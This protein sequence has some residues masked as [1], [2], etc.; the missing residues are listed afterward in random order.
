VSELARWRVL[1][2]HS[3]GKGLSGEPDLTAAIGRSGLE[4]DAFGGAAQAWGIGSEVRG[5]KMA[6]V[7]ST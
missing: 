5:R 6:A 2:V 4:C 7:R 3:W 1:W